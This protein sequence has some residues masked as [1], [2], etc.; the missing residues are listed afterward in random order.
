MS[1]R[2]RITRDDVVKEL[3]DIIATRGED[4]IYEVP[5]GAGGTCM[6]IWDDAPSCLIGC[7]LVSKGVPIDAFKRFE[8]SAI[9]DAYDK[10]C[11]PIAIETDA[12]SLL[13]RIQRYQDD[14]YSWG[15]SFINA[16]EGN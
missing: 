15:T 3:P 5:S 13:S 1:F 14:S 2:T 6:Y 7:Y 9:D 11:V 16:I 12:L 8:G 10:G 4:F